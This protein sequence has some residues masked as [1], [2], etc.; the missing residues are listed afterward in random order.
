M[1]SN[2]NRR[3]AYHGQGQAHARHPVEQVDRVGSKG[4][5]V[6]CATSQ[7][8]NAQHMERGRRRA[9]KFSDQKQKEPNRR[10]FGRVSLAADAGQK[11]LAA[12]ISQRDLFGPTLKDD[13]GAEPEKDEGDETGIKGHHGSLSLRRGRMYL[14]SGRLGPEMRR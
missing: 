5:G 3:D 14:I 13:P 4:Q 9:L 12:V 1:R 11:R 10:I 2:A 6:E 8:K 7:K